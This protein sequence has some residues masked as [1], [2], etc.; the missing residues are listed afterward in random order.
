MYSVVWR[1][2]S[3]P[4]FKLNTGIAWMECRLLTGRS[5]CA[6]C[7]QVSTGCGVRCERKASWGWQVA[8]AV[9]KSCCWVWASSGWGTETAAVCRRPAT[10]LDASAGNWPLLNQLHRGDLKPTSQ[11]I[12]RFILTSHDHQGR[13]LYA[14]SLKEIIKASKA[15]YAER[16]VFERVFLKPCV[17]K[18]GRE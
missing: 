7:S 1:S 6:R 15:E 9:L 3:I 5:A 2:H 12:H 16:N 10:G 11:G 17:E 4:I 14:R 18:L 8:A 13:G